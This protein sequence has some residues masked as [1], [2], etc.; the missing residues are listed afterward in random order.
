MNNF[1]EPMLYGSTT[2]IPPVAI[3]IAAVFWT[4][5]W[6]GIGLLLSV[7]LTVCLVVMGRY[8]PSLQFLAILFSDEEV[9]RPEIKFYQRMLSMDLD[10]AREIAQDFLKEKGTSVEDLEDKVMIPALIMAEEDRHRGLL[11]EEHQRF[12]FENTRMLLEDISEAVADGKDPE[13][14]KPRRSD[15]EPEITEPPLE[16]A[17][18][19]CIPARDEADEIAARMIALLLNQ[20]GTPARLLSSDSLA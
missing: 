8:F 5:L 16:E 20:R 7:P 15:A 2:G 17:Q 9:L 11:D 14:L 4:W 19:F 3:L 18:V 10:E 12:F 6:G 13:A 1:A